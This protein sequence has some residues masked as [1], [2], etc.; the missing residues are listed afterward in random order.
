M[1]R[2]MHTQRSTS[3]PTFHACPKSDLMDALHTALSKLKGTEADDADILEAVNIERRIS[4][5]PDV[6]VR[7]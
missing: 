1:S 7:L 5:K 4:K 2:Q 6:K 3:W